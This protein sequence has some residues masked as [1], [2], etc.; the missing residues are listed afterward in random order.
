MK[1]FEKIN[2]DIEPPSIYQSTDI[3][4]LCDCIKQNEDLGE[5]RRINNSELSEIE[6]LR[7]F[8]HGH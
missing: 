5:L 8:L 4:K 7:K 3:P 2:P 6:I 1:S